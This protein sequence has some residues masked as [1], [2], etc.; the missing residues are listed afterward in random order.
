MITGYNCLKYHCLKSWL[1]KMEADGPPQPFSPTDEA[2]KITAQRHAESI[3]RLRAKIEEMRVIDD[4][5]QPVMEK[6]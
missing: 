2:K 5:R 6:L 1:A 4:S 3:G